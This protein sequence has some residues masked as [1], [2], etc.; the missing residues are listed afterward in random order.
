MSEDLRFPIGRF[1]AEGKDLAGERE[2]YI[3]TI[4]SLPRA[5][6]A[7]VEGLTDEQLQFPYRPDGWSV[8]QV[9]HHVADSHMNSFIRFK[10]ALTEEQPLIK[11]YREELW[12]EMPDVLEVPIEA[13]L[14][15]I[16]GVHSRWG[17]LLRSMKPEDF[18]RKLD[19]PEHGGVDLSYVAGLYDW[20]SRHHT[21]HIT[22]LR[23]RKG[24]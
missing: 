21:A 23:E 10:L 5:L 14:S 4:E 7:A 24:W 18:S 2:Q 16:R 1:E 8:A 20:H 15:I 11:T 9:V 17:V 3:Q 6:L 19:H 12:A 13:S 22:R